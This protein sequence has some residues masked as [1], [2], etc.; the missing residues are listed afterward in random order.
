MSGW[1]PAEVM[2]RKAHRSGYVATA[3]SEIW[4]QSLTLREMW[5]FKFAT[6]IKR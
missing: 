3:I 5:L 4:G 6:L 2:L 1:K